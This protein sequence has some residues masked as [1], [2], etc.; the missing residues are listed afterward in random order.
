MAQ[1]IKKLN[2]AKPSILKLPK[3]ESTPLTPVITGTAAIFT[4]DPIERA[5]IRLK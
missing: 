1:R 3:Q 4:I 5:R 2:N